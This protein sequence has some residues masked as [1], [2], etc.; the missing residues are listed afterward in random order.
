MAMRRRATQ[1]RPSP[2]P[3]DRSKRRA[4]SATK[5]CLRTVS[6][7]ESGVMGCRSQPAATASSPRVRR[8]RVCL[9]SS[10]RR[11]GSGKQ[12]LCSRTLNAMT[13]TSTGAHP[14]HGGR[15]RAAGAAAAR[16]PAEP[17][18]VAP[19]SLR[20]WPTGTRSS[21]P[22]YVGTATR[23]DPHRRA[24]HAS[25][26]K[27]AMAA[28][29]VGLMRRARLREL[30]A[31]RPRPRRPSRAPAVPGP[32][33]GGLPGRTPRHRPDPAR[34]RPRR[35]RPGAGVLPLVLP[36]PGPATYPST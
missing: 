5:C 35:P 36:L 9:G 16:L 27:R 7:V 19:A 29:Q 17:R 22:T 8:R 30:R 4:V 13:S 11:P 23:P 31:R 6:M 12:G 14:R 15:R 28:D 1:S 34:V 10:A 18:D 32:P 24:D 20:S 26:S 25:Y 33:R 3:E 2:G 21:S